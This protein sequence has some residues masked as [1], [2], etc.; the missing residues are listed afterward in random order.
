MSAVSGLEQTNPRGG[1]AVPQVN[2]VY[3]SALTRDGN[4]ITDLTATD[5]VLKEGGSTR[6]IVKVQHATEPLH[7]A[8]II[9]DSGTG[10]FRFAIAN[11]I[12]QLLGHARFSIK[13]VV[14]QVQT[15][16]EY[17]SDVDRLRE[18][19]QGLKVMTDTPKGGQVVEGILDTA[20]ELRAL[21][22]SRPV[23]VVFTDTDAEYSTV[24]AAHVLDQLQQS[25]ALLYVISSAR[26]A[27]T[28]LPGQTATADKPSDLLDRQLDVNQ[29][30]GDGPRQSGG[31]RAEIVGTAGPIPA[32]QSIGEEL[33]HQYVVTYI[34]PSGAKPNQKISV[35]TKRRDVVVRAP[36]RAGRSIQ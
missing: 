2:V 10:I 12:D 18:A 17:T 5:L 36:S 24:S 8:M 26:I 34:T 13:R 35:S 3:V 6:E 16:V 29:V 27:T 14:G 9:D 21:S 28:S 22:V 30:L 31:R 7:V 23:I 19:V 4:P 33:N 15:L 25:G 11:F 32:L 1:S 20:K